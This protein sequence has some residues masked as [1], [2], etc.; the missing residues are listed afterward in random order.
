MFIKKNKNGVIRYFAKKDA[1][2]LLNMED[3]YCMIVEDVLDSHGVP[4]PTVDVTTDATSNMF[5][6]SLEGHT[7]PL[8]AIPYGTF[9]T[10]TETETIKAVNNLRK[11]IW[12]AWENLDTWEI[13]I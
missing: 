12:N 6:V 5:Y 1:A 3:I 11:D 4:H 7:Q 9:I 10:E 8:L 13:E 2:P